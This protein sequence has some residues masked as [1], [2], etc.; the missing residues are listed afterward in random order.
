MISLQITADKA[1]RGPNA[2]VS[3]KC[4]SMQVI[5]KRIIH[6]YRKVLLTLWCCSVIFDRKIVRFGFKLLHFLLH[7]NG[8]QFDKSLNGPENSH[9]CI[10]HGQK[11]PHWK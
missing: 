8:T 11:L 2:W 9:T 4:V 3:V 10:V 1:I 6:R 7:W 5:M